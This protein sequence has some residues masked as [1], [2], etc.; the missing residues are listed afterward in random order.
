MAYIYDAVI[1]GPGKGQKAKVLVV[2]SFHA[3]SPTPRFLPHYQDGMREIC[4]NWANEYQLLPTDQMQN[5]DTQIVSLDGRVQ[6]A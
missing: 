1:G 3:C 6:K 2:V 5:R 4:K